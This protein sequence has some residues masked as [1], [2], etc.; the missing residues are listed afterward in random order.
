MTYRLTAIL[1]E[2]EKAG[3]K[4]PRLIFYT[5]DPAPFNPV[6][7]NWERPSVFFSINRACPVDYNKGCYLV[8]ANRYKTLEEAIE[9]LKQL[10]KEKP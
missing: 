4:E 7:I 10:L 3:L 1:N 6:D 8:N 9:K 2:L 5:A